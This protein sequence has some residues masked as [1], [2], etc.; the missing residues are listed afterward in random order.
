M[1]LLGVGG[2]G[3][4]ASS[5]TVWGFRVAGILGRWPEEDIEAGE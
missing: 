1:K 2:L 4:R 5:L 3:L